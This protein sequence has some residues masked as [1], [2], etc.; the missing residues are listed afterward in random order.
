MKIALRKI[1]LFDK[2]TCLWHFDKRIC[3]WHLAFFFLGMLT[4]HLYVN[5]FRDYW[6]I[7]R[8]T[9]SLVD[10]LQNSDGLHKG[11]WTIRPDGRLGNQ[12]GEYATLYA[13]SLL[14]GY[15]AVILPEMHNNLAPIFK[16]TLPVID[17]STADAVPWQEYHLQDWMSD[18]Y[19]HINRPF[20][21]L[22]GYPCS[23]T[24]YHHIRKKILREFTFQDALKQE[25]NDYL[26]KIRKG[27]KTVTYIAVHVRR[28]DYVEVMP[29]VWKGVIGDKLY[30]KKAMDYFRRRYKDAVFV[31]TSNDMGWCKNN[32]ENSKG[33]VH[34]IGDGAESHPGRDFAILSHCNH[35]VMSIGT[36]GFWAAYLAG[37][38]T[39]YLTNFT[40]PD[41]EFLKL[42]HYDAAFL[43]NWIGIPADLTP[44]L[45]NSAS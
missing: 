36:F 43:P 32:I 5:K 37:G 22:R 16:V 12:M 30:F 35:T 38:D 21:K 8:V 34:Y 23:W 28:G 39:V 1:M 11:L 19:K 10:H 27:L 44:L 3:F 25:A 13:L 31:V 20:I 9:S 29:K 41:S 40:L 24:F 2:R 17:Q 7:Q 33:D 18:E 4:F 45:Q 15:K 14:N 42:F 26:W 6:L